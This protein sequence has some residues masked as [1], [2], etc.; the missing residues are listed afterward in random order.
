MS[1]PQQADCDACA[2]GEE[3]TNWTSTS[4]VMNVVD[5]VTAT[6]Q[7]FKPVNIAQFIGTRR[8]MRGDKGKKMYFADFSENTDAYRQD[9]LFPALNDACRLDGFFASS[10]GYQRNPPVARIICNR[11]KVYRVLRP[12]DD[13]GASLD[14]GGGGEGSAPPSVAA[15]AKRKRKSKTGRALSVEDRCHFTFPIFWDEERKLWYIWER[16][17]GCPKHTGHCRVPP[18]EKKKRH[19]EVLRRGGEESVC[20]EE[21]VGHDDVGNRH[22]GDAGEG[23]G[24][25]QED[26]GEK[27]DSHDDCNE[28]LPPPCADDD[29]AAASSTI[30]PAAAAAVQPIA[31]SV[32]GVSTPQLFSIAENVIR[33]KRQQENLYPLFSDLCSECDDPLT[34]LAC[35]QG[36]RELHAK[37]RARKASS[38]SMAVNN[39]VDSR[40]FAPFRGLDGSEALYQRY[41]FGNPDPRTMF[42][43]YHW[44]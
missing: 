15:G 33:P 6:P 4:I 28:N 23:D 43:G 44:P 32:T 36:L 29:A 7:T 13:K 34:Y 42:N 30:R 21:A 20:E 8:G 19:T 41:N 37:L 22:D 11:S 39:N 40:L 16:S 9:V 12:K 18:G 2:R 10:R 26:G 24:S 25:S 17:A 1:A 38:S 27:D 14:G 3:A 35:V 31:P 5:D